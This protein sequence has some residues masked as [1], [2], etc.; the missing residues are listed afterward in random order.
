MAVLPSPLRSFHATGASLKIGE[1]A[2]GQALTTKFNLPD[3]TRDDTCPSYGIKPLQLSKI[4]ATIGPTSEQ[5]EPLTE[6]VRHG[7]SVMRLNFSHATKEE[8][9]L[10][11]KNIAI[12]EVHFV[13]VVYVIFFR[14]FSELTLIIMNTCFKSIFRKNLLQLGPLKCREFAPCCWI[15]EDLK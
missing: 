7:M 10:R 15:R 11:C 9:E 8:V 12:A 14:L 5:L 4:V 13:Y 1:S 6:V 3:P 2:S